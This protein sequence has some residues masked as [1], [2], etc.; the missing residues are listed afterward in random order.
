MCYLLSHTVAAATKIVDQSHLTEQPSSR[1]PQAPPAPREEYAQ[2]EY[3]GLPV[4]YSVLRIMLYTN[5][6][7]V[8][9]VVGGGDQL[10]H[11]L[12][13]HESWSHLALDDDSSDESAIRDR[14]QRAASPA[15]SSTPPAGDCAL[16][17]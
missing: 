17:L 13:E 11:C 10:R 6:I 5:N 14:R 12:F 9:L 7:Y 15:C 2:I 3:A 4:N 1:T 16:I 8:H